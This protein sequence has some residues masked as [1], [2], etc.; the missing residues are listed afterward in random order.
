[1]IIEWMVTRRA[2]IFSFSTERV[3]T[4]WFIFISRDTAGQERYR[5]LAA[6][7]FRD[8]KVGLAPSSPHK[9]ICQ[10]G[11]GVC[12]SLKWL[13]MAREMF[14]L[15]INHNHWSRLVWYNIVGIHDTPCQYLL[16]ME[17]TLSD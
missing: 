14:R 7:T 1:M 3:A 2:N 5:S 4:L 17:L 11:F 9:F 12:T 8:A 16:I 13:L 15:G 6:S 10:C